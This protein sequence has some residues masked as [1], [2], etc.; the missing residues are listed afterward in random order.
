MKSSEDIIQEAY[1]ENDEEVYWSLIA[2]LHK[3]GTVNEFN[4][5]VKLCDSEDPVDREIGADIL[6]Q[7]GWQKKAFQEESIP[8]LI[9]LLSD[10]VDDAI[11]SAAYALGHRN[12]AEAVKPLLR[13]KKHPNPRVRHGVVFGLL[14]LEDTDA[15]NCLIDLTND[16]DDEVR[17][18]A[19]FGLGSLIDVNSDDIRDALEKR[20]TDSVSEIRGEAFVGLAARGCDSI[21]EML[22]QELNGTDIGTLMLEAAGI[23][24]SPSLYQPL[25][26]IQN[27]LK[28]NDS[29]YFISRLSDALDSCSK[30][31]T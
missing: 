26:T 10:P 25:K 24:A 22:I 5:S 19:T 12:A 21:V 18:W 31:I 9:E 3:R 28:D 8:I 6:G 1:L 27:T 4:L 16:K 30:N 20:L 7:L 23:L 11:S 17:N 14:S 13:H 2:E 29:E 15:I